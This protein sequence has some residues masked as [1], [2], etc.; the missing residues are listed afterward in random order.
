MLI[1]NIPESFISS[2]TTGAIGPA[3]WGQEPRPQLFTRS[4]FTEQ[5]DRRSIKK[6]V[7]AN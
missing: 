1:Q 2:N 6:A 7:S 4:K 3:G 5:Y